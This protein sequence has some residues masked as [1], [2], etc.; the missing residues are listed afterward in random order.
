[1]TFCHRHRGAALIASTLLAPQALF[2]A[3]KPGGGVLGWVENTQGMPVAGAVISLFGK[4]IRGGSLV[5]LSDTTGQFFLPSL[6][7]GSY[8]LRALG[9]GHEPAPAQTITVLPQTDSVF[10]V[11]LTPFGESGEGAS[12]PSFSDRTET[13][14]TAAAREEL[15]WLLRHKRRSV[16][17]YQD[18][19]A[20]ADVSAEAPVAAR[21]QG[22]RVAVYAPSLAGTFEVVATPAVIGHDGVLTVADGVPTSLGVLRLHGK[23]ADI[24]EW[25]LGGLVTESENTAWRM[26]AEF[27]LSP[28]G[29]HEIQTGGGYGTRYVRPL[30]GEGLGATLDARSVGSLFA[31]DTWRVSEGWTAGFGARYSYVGFLHDANSVDGYASL[32]RALGRDG[33]MRGSVSIRT[34]APGGDLLTLSTLGSAPVL[35]LTR[36]DDAL[37]AERTMRYELGVDR[38]AGGTTV[39]AFVFREDVADQLVNIHGMAANDALRIVNGGGLEVQGV[40]MSLERRF[41]NSV[42]GSLTYC[43]GRTSRHGEGRTTSLLREVPGFSAD[44]SEAGFHDLVA[45]L[46]TFIDLTDTRLTAYYRVNTLDPKGDPTSRSVTNARFDIRLTQG[47]PFMQPLTRADWELLVAVRNLFYDELEGGMLDEVAVLHPPKRVMG[48]FAVKF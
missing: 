21:D 12:E 41:G 42:N 17:E 34:L 35:G 16:L 15:K 18:D 10:T 37:R 23:M 20:I 11:S 33:R 1:L 7:A 2:A 48:G 3:E 44:F 24:G 43:Y 28:G 36:I 45:R 26:A 25:R 47:L 38:S 5:T 39:G 14:R 13:D 22:D 32:E 8:T 46:E 27:V 4:G 31:H 9:R 29:G 40:G 19:E 30:A 6:P